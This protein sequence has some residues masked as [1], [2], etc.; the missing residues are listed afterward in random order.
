MLPTAASNLGNGI[1]QCWQN[2]IYTSGLYEKDSY[3]FVSMLTR[4]N[5]YQK[6]KVA[7]N[8][9]DFQ[10]LKISKNF[11]RSYM[12]ENENSQFLHDDAVRYPWC[13][14]SDISLSR[15]TTINYYEMTKYATKYKCV[16][17]YLRKWNLNDARIES[18]QLRFI[19]PGKGHG[20]YVPAL[21]RAHLAAES[22]ISVNKVSLG[23][24]GEGG[25]GRADGSAAGG[26]RHPR[27][28]YPLP[29]TH[30][31][32]RARGH[33][34]ARVRARTRT[35]SCGRSLLRMRGG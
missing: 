10:G 31:R 18:H 30:T 20:R 4:V 23:L 29:A 12:R 34:G 11:Y 16:F 19:T 2:K 9:Y 24:W 5:F 27:T 8:F 25:G 17:I 26:E 35:Q 13:N 32:A 3:C 7:S 33:V 15:R 6:F 21:A 14:C 1:L 22:V 28:T